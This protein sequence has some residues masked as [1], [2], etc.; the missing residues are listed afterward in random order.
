MSHEDKRIDPRIKS[1]MKWQLIFLFINFAAAVFLGWWLGQQVFDPATSPVLFGLS[2]G[3]L[4]ALLIRVLNYVTLVVLQM[5]HYGLNVS[6]LVTDAEEATAIMQGK[7]PVPI[8]KD[9]KVGQLDFRITKKAR[10]PLGKFMDE[11]FYEWIEIASGEQTT[12]LY[13]EGT[14]DLKKAT[15]KDIPSDC[16]VLPPGIIYKPQA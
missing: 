1:I 6:Q 3:L 5:I 11:Y 4:A 12:R 10:K 8:E 13:F 14:L 2:T 7:A 9:P 15:V 16:L